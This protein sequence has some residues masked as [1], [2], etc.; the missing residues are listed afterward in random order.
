MTDIWFNHALKHSQKQ[1]DIFWSEVSLSEVRFKGPKFKHKL[2][3]MQ[4]SWSNWLKSLITL[5]LE[6]FWKWL[7]LKSYLLLYKHEETFKIC[8]FESRLKIRHQNLKEISLK[9][10]WLLFY[11][12][13]E[14]LNFQCKILLFNKCKLHSI[15]HFV[16]LKQINSKSKIH[17]RTN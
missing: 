12:G 15:Y 17:L 8:F 1:S 10:F 7:H 16:I 2:T 9:I 5:M 3:E 11:Y 14:C 6:N 4:L 13:N